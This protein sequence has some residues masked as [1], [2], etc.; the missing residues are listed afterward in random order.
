MGICCLPEQSRYTQVMIH[1]YSYHLF[2]YLRRILT[3]KMLHGAY[4][5]LETIL[6]N[7]YS[8]FIF[9]YVESIKNIIVNDTNVMAD[10]SKMC[11]ILEDYKI[12]VL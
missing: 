8:Y 5:R 2:I 6:I 7:I 10:C 4:Y 3:M 9:L 1:S 12:M 11:L